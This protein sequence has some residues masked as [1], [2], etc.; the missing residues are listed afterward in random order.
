[1]NKKFYEK[2]LKKLQA[3]KEELRKK[4]LASDD[5]NEVRD[6]SE[7]IEELNHL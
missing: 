4:A 3:K 2:R 6:L 1:M 5:V 7:R